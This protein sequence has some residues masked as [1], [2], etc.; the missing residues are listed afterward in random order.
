MKEVDRDKHQGDLN[1]S[2]W[3]AYPMLSHI[4]EKE[5]KILAKSFRQMNKAVPIVRTD[6]FWPRQT[7][8]CL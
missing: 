1:G 7:F 6:S 4:N 8:I 3:M 2:W 5:E